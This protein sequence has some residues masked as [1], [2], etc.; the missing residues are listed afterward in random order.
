[1]STTTLIHYWTTVT[2]Y[3]SIWDYAALSTS[4]KTKISIVLLKST[5]EPTKLQ[6]FGDNDGI[7][8]NS[9]LLEPIPKPMLLKLFNANHPYW[10]EIRIA[11]KV[12]SI[13]HL[14][15]TLLH[16]WCLKLYSLFSFASHSSHSQVH[17][18]EISFGKDLELLCPLYFKTSR[19]VVKSSA[20]STAIPE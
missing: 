15:G 2:I 13:V 20:R 19:L 6:L 9:C 17:K 16:V 11:L 5:T 4:W 3:W 1:M 18:G 8:A 7:T 14:N 12:F 10:M